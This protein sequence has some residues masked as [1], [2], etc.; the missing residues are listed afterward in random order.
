[1]TKIHFSYTNPAR[2]ARSPAAP[3]TRLDL[4]ELDKVAAG[5]MAKGIAESTNRAYRSAQNRFMKFCGEAG[6]TPVPASEE[7]L[8]FFVAHL[9]VQHR[10]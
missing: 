8:C 1:M 2:S 3:S 4:A 10:L 5:L 6:L 7:V 9:Q